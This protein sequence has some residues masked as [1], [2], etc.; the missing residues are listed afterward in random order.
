MLRP[1]HHPALVLHKQFQ[2]GMENTAFSLYK[3]RYFY[4]VTKISALYIAQYLQAMQCSQCSQLTEHESL[5]PPRARKRPL[6][7]IWAKLRNI[8][9]LRQKNSLCFLCDAE[10]VLC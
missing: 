8:Y 2:A 4:L 1:P 7:Q 9:N 5:V 6:W 3:T 10:M